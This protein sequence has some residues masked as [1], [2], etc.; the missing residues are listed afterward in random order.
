[1]KKMFGTAFIAAI[2]VSVCIFTSCT[3][4]NIEPEVLRV[5]KE[6]VLP[7]GT[8]ADVYFFKD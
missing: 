8:V 6:M 3:S 5:E 1:M 2:F 7:D 4:A